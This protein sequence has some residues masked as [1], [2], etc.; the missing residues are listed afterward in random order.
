M[1]SERVKI[2]V[3]QPRLWFGPL[4]V[5]SAVLSSL[6]TIS[7]PCDCNY[8]VIAA[9]T[10]DCDMILDSSLSASLIL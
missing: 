1:T 3:K 6:I 5:F 4:V 2:L 9:C 8:C 7:Y 10:E